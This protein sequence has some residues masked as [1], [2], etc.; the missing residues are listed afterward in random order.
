MCLINQDQRHRC[1]FARAEHG[2]EVLLDRTL[3][4]HKENSTRPSVTAARA[5]FSSDADNELFSN[6]AE[7]SASSSFSNWSFISEIKDEATN[8]RPPSHSAGS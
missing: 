7:I 3:G 5:C 1:L 2:D 8:V 4:C 6:A